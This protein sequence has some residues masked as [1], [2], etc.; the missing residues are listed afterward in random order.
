[1][2]FISTQEYQKQL[3]LVTG[4]LAVYP[5]FVEYEV[6][7]AARRMD[8]GL[9]KKINFNL[10]IYLFFS[11][12]LIIFLF[13]FIFLIFFIDLKLLIRHVRTNFYII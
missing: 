9:K 10:L 2:L 6:D 4:W 12:F 3:Q 13:F 8:A 1:M 7:A 5:A 11:S